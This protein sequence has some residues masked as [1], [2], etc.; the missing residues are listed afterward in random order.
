[1]CACMFRTL[2]IRISTTPSGSEHQFGLI[3]AHIV[4]YGRIVGSAIF[5][6]FHANNS[7]GTEQ[8]NKVARY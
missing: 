7:D 2:A 6:P 4:V 8:K 1:M 3:R 5:L